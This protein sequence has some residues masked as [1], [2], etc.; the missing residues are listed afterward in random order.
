MPSSLE[1]KAFSGFLWSLSGSFFQKFIGIS[2]GVVLARLLGPEI[3]GEIALTYVILE[4]SETLLKGGF[5]EA[6]IRQNEIN[7]EDSNTVFWINLL[8]A[9]LLCCLIFIL[10]PFYGSFLQTGEQFVSVVRVSSIVLLLRSIIIVQ[11]AKLVN[12]IKYKQLQIISSIAMIFASS[13]A[14]ILALIDQSIWALV[15]RNLLQPFVVLI[16]LFSLNP[17]LPNGPIIPNR[18]KQ[19]FSFGGRILVSSIVD[20]LYR[21]VQRIL[22]G[23]YFS[24]DTL[25]MYTQAE[26][27]KVHSTKTIVDSFQQVSYPVLSKISKQLEKLRIWYRDLSKALAFIVFPVSTLIFNLSDVIVFI[28]LGEDWKGTGDMLRVMIVAGAIYF[29]PALNK[30]LLKVLGD[31]KGVLKFEVVKKIIM[32]IFLLV[33]VNYSIDVVLLAE[34]FAFIII[35]F[36]AILITNKILNVSIMEQINQLIVPLL[37]SVPL[38]I[39]SYILVNNLMFSLDWVTLFIYIIVISTSVFLYLFIGYSMKIDFFLKI[40]HKF[41]QLLPNR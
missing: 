9:L 10:A 18:L 35:S 24:I 11:D 26:F 1:E 32:L 4:I 17:W 20:K 34:L 5:R 3:F 21:S 23:K 15:L 22:L 40:T 30:N 16:L 33:A 38:F 29:V 39:S 7:D 28:V 41:R 2:T 31:A 27:L 8:V 12:Q 37:L 14:L 6:L 36:F 19:L 13:A 25:G